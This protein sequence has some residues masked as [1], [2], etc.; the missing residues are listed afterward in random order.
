MH[1]SEVHAT[2]SELAYNRELSTPVIAPGTSR[3][4]EALHALDQARRE[5][6]RTLRRRLFGSVMVRL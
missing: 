6:G 4:Y 5:E 3:E 2:L 1:P